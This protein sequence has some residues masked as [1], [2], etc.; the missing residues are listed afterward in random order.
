MSNIEIKKPKIDDTIKPRRVAREPLKQSVSTL[1]QRTGN[2]IKMRPAP[3]P[4]KKMSSIT[5]AKVKEREEKQKMID[6]VNRL[7]REKMALEDRIILLEMKLSKSDVLATVVLPTLVQ[8]HDA[9]IQDHLLQ[10][11]CVAK[12]LSQITT[13]YTQKVMQLENRV[14]ERDQ[15]KHRLEHQVR[16]LNNQLIDQINTTNAQ[17]ELNDQQLSHIHELDGVISGFNRRLEEVTKDNDARVQ[18]KVQELIAPWIGAKAQADS[19]QI[20]V[21]IKNEMNRSLQSKLNMSRQ[22]IERLS[23]ERDHLQMVAHLAEEKDEKLNK[24]GTENRQLR[25]DLETSRTALSAREAEVLDLSFN[26][27]EEKYRQS[28]GERPINSSFRAV[29]DEGDTDGSS[30][31]QSRLS[32]SPFD[33]SN[34][35]VFN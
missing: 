32:Q 27:E 14:L 15:E 26:L 25:D 19:F 9:V 17:R 2:T 28:I 31:N 16:V 13:H 11:E 10:Q 3:V 5:A 21:E 4:L 23:S 12:Q 18:S 30:A 22:S 35:D 29:Y 24:L 6:H 8:K 33:K 1:N 20:E 34:D 7:E